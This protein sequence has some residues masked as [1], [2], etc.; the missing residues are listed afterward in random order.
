MA[1]QHPD[2]QAPQDSA[3]RVDHERDDPVAEGMTSPS[4]EYNEASSDVPPGEVGRNPDG[5]P[6]ERDSEEVDRRAG[7]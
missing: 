1:K 2:F 4:F 7:L 5:E 3:P 6:G